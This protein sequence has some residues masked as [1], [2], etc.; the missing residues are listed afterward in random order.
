ME[1]E[2]DEGGAGESFG[3]ACLVVSLAWVSVQIRQVTRYDSRQT[4]FA[5]ALR[6]IQLQPVLLR[7]K[8]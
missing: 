2:M 5:L 4:A 7:F 3:S 1:E 8:R 6:L